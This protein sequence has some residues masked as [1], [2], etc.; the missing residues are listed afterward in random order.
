MI[1]PNCGGE[2][3]GKKCPYC[4][5]RFS[6]DD[7]PRQAQA[8]FPGSAPSGSAAGQR[9]DEWHDE[10]KSWDEDERDLDDGSLPVAKL[11][12][13][14]AKSP[15]MLLCTI[16]A[17]L[18]AGGICFTFGA[19]SLSMTKILIANNFDSFYSSDKLG[20]TVFLIACF[21]HIG[22][23]VWLAV[24]L[25]SLFC[26]AVSRKKPNFD[27]GWFNSMQNYVGVG[28]KLFLLLAVLSAATAV[29]VLADVD[30]S[31]GLF[32]SVAMGASSGAM[33]VGLSHVITLV[34]EDNT[35]RAGV[36][37][38]VFL[39]HALR[40]LMLTQSFSVA[41]GMLRFDE[42]TRWKLPPV[43]AFCFLGGVY[44]VGV[45]AFSLAKFGTDTTLLLLY[46]P[47][48]VLGLTLLFC[49]V[50]LHRAC[51]GVKLRQGK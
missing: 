1:C 33:H 8:P 29:M 22:M 20:R 28:R 5:A 11:L 9:D 17:T 30:F 31:N 6:E 4:G 45:S 16:L 21:V 49:A 19:A 46:L 25:W 38:L 35:I 44:Y 2:L 48:F 12:R 40:F 18:Y 41:G 42:V 27:V 37:I 7:A 36:L 15:L 51:T 34:T 13:K 32:Y 43:A 10:F 14:L 23:A 3:S 47:L 26:S 39:F 24:S 50:L